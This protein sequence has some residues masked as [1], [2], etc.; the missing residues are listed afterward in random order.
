MYNYE[1]WATLKS[2]NGN[3]GQLVRSFRNGMPEAFCVFTDE[4][5]VELPTETE[6]EEMAKEWGYEIDYRVVPVFA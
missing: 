6:A 5:V 2:P 3:T 1:L 4:G